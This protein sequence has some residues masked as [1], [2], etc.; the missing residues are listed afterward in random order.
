MSVIAQFHMAGHNSMASTDPHTYDSAPCPFAVPMPAVLLGVWP[1]RQVGQ[2]STASYRNASRA[3]RSR[4]RSRRRSCGQGAP[5]ASGH[6]WSTSKAFRVRVGYPTAETWGP[7]AQALT[8]GVTGEVTSLM[9]A[10]DQQVISRQEMIESV[11]NRTRAEDAL[12]DT[13]LAAGTEPNTRRL[14]EAAT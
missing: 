10:A 11:E 8:T 12:V 2:R 9:A 5:G 6:T 13:P 7:R 14:V 1:F 3:C 4:G